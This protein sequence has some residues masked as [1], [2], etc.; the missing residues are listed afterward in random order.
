LLAAEARAEDAEEREMELTVEAGIGRVLDSRD[1]T[2]LDLPRAKLGLL[3]ENRSKDEEISAKNVELESKRVRDGGYT[4][5]RCTCCNVSVE[6][7]EL[8]IGRLDRV[9]RAFGEWHI[10][11][12]C[13]DIWMLTDHR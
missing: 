12:V 10:A 7:G 1:E 11:V 9:Y 13:L 2:I 4:S 6:A 5:E 8:G 3:E